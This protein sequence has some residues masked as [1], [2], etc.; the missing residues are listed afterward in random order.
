MAFLRK[1]QGRFRTIRLNINI[2]LEEQHLTHTAADHPGIVSCETLVDT[3]IALA[4]LIRSFS[5]RG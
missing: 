1:T 5:T 4:G 3:A 2:D